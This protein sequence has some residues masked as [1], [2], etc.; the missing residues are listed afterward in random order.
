[1]EIFAGVRFGAATLVQGE[2]LLAAAM[3][4]YLPRPL[5]SLPFLEQLLGMPVGRDSG[6]TGPRSEG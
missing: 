6:L 2:A 1:V 5:R 3:Q 4:P